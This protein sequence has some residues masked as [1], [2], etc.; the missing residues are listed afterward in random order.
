MSNFNEDVYKTAEVIDQ[1]YEEYNSTPAELD[2]YMKEI[3]SD[4]L[5]L[6]AD[7]CC[8]NIED[9]LACMKEQKEVG[10]WE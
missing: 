2:R 8:C 10:E 7:P 3:C 4:C 5:Y 1:M 6:E 9:A